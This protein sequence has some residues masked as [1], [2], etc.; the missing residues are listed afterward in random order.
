MQSAAQLGSYGLDKDDQ[1][2]DFDAAG[3]GTGAAAGKEH[4]GQHHASK[5]WPFIVIIGH[6]ASGAGKGRNV[7]E[8]RTQTSFN[9][10]TIDEDNIYRDGE[11]EAR[12]DNDVNLELQVLP[13]GLNAVLRYLI[14]HRKVTRCQNHKEA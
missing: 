14:L 11:G 9:R 8:C 2:A 4:H 6:K 1:A 13:Q 3:G 5:G 12:H 7:E 10:I